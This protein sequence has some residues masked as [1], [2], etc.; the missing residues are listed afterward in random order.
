MA[1]DAGV[2]RDGGGLSKAPGP[3]G[4]GLGRLVRRL[5]DGVG[6]Y[7]GLRERFGDVV[8]FRILH[9]RFV[10]VFGADAIRE[11]LVEKEGCFEKGPALKSTPV[12]KNPTTATAE[13]E[14]HRRLRGMV[15]PWFTRS[16]LMGYG[17][18][19]VIEAEAVAESWKDGE[20]VDLVKAA[21]V[22]CAA[23]AGAAFFGRDVAVERQLLEDTVLALRWSMVVSLVPGG[24]VLERLP[25]GRNRVR[26]AAG[27][28]M[29]EVV[30]KA[31]RNADGDPGRTDLVSMLVRLGEED[32][33][34]RVM[35]EDEVRDEMY[36]LLIEAYVNPASAIGW[37]LWFLSGR[38][39]SRG[40]LEREVDRVVGGGPLEVEAYSELKFAQAVVSE[41][42][43]LRPPV[44]VVGRR[45]LKDCEIGG[46]RVTK[47]TTVHP[48]LWGLQR[49]SELFDAAGEFRPER[50]M[51][52]AGED[53]RRRGYMPFGAG[54][55]SCL[56]A[57]FAK[58]EAVYFLA[59]VARRW[60]VDPVDEGEPE[61]RSLGF[62]GF[63]DGLPVQVRARPGA[64][65]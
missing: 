45:A 63:R 61:V 37:C 47:G 12:L 15:K 29:D 31:V 36:E 38:P 52:G 49:D 55:R 30:G 8:E 16:S 2:R 27:R 62:Y 56:G 59:A 41:A 34:F 22:Y 39:E 40:E 32:A 28:R 11:V 53:A 6:F 51:E 21:R 33:G 10:A 24:G 19:M 48:V 43:R 42:L 14:D 57:A 17:K 44:Y 23:V 58:M 4:P 18:E 9:R 65:M 50:W 60:R 13:G 7:E 25:I 64:V 5:R 26:E 1:M 20:T 54:P 3:K 46:F 35:R